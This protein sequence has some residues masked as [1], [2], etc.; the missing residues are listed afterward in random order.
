[1]SPYIALLKLERQIVLLNNNCAEL[2][3]QK[4]EGITAKLLLRTLV[5][6]I[7]RSVPF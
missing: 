7:N 3:E 1:M 5:S 6:P 4:D 2:Q